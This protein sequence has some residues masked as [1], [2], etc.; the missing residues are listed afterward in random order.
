MGPTREKGSF[1]AVD[2]AGK[3][4]TIKEFVNQ[5]EYNSSGPSGFID[6]GIFTLKTKNGDVVK[7]V[8]KG[9]YL[10]MPENGENILVT[11]QDPN[12]PE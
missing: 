4:Y 6:G 9:L 3:K 10:I 12:A 7:I 8:Q 11:S 2:D 1:V 5:V